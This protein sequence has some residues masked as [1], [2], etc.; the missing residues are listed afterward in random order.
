MTTPTESQ[1][2]TAKAVPAEPKYSVLIFPKDLAGY[3]DDPGEIPPPAS[4]FLFADFLKDLKAGPIFCESITRDKYRDLTGDQN[5][6][7]LD[8]RLAYPAVSIDNYSVYLT[9]ADS[10]EGPTS[11]YSLL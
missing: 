1:R 4:Q 7:Q 2:A 3:P 8:D 5:C 6:A 10:V 11:T 9:A